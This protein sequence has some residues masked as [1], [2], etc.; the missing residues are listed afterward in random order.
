MKINTSVA[1]ATFGLLMMAMPA[2]ASAEV[3]WYPRPVHPVVVQEVVQPAPFTPVGYYRP[4][5]CAQPA[6][7]PSSLVE[8]PLTDRALP[9]LDNPRTRASERLGLTS[10][11]NLLRG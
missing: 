5:A 7:P 9:G 1:A 11:R 8:M 4:F 6:L 2:V 10:R 3:R